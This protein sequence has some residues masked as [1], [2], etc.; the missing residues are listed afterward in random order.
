MDP[1]SKRGQ[2]ILETLFM[3]SL[4]LGIMYISLKFSQIGQAIYQKHNLERK[5][6]SFR[7]NKR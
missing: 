3:F 2:L 6:E 7:K 5:Y 1:G 4:M